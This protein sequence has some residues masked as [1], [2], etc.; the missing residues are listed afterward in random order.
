MMSIVNTYGYHINVVAVTTGFL[1]PD[2][3]VHY[4]IFSMF[5]LT[6]SCFST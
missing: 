1:F 6:I 3:L 2:L 4:R 5:F